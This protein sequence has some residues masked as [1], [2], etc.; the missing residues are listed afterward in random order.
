MTGIATPE[1]ATVPGVTA[2]N[3]NTIGKIEDTEETAV[4]PH[5]NMARVKCNPTKV[6]VD[7]TT[8]ATTT[9]ERVAESKDA[10]SAE[11]TTTATTT[12]E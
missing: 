10:G 7:I 1:K 11:I 2:A 5:P 4:V 6:A 8:T 3:K 12:S 9:S